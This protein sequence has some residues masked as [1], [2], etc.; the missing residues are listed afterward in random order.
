M[1]QV[2]PGPE[3]GDPRQMLGALA[4]DARIRSRVPRLALQTLIAAIAAFWIGPWAILW[5]AIMQGFEHK[6]EPW[7][8]ATVAPKLTP[9]EAARARIGLRF[10]MA[11]LF[12]LSWAP[13]WAVGGDSAAFFAAIMLSG[14]LIHS[15]VY[16]SNT[17]NV[18]YASIAPP[19]AAGVITPLVFH[20]AFGAHLLVIPILGV[21]LLRAHWAQRDQNALFERL[22]R[23]RE[24]RKEAEE[25]SR[26]KSRFLEIITHELRTP[27][28]AV[29]GYA[30]ILKDDLEADGKRALAADAEGIR[31]AGWR[32]LALV[33]DVIDF[34]HLDSGQL[35]ALRQQVDVG[36]VIEE[37][38]RQCAPL[39]A[40]GVA[41]ESELA[42][43]VGVIVTDRRR[44]EQCLANLLSNA[45]RF[46][47]RGRILI[48][49]R[50]VEGPER[51]LELAVED[52]GCGIAP[53]KVETL[54]E[55]FTQADASPTRAKDGLGLGLAI[56]R[57]LG[58]L[59]GGDVVVRSTPGV[60]S[61][62][63]LTVLA[64]PAASLHPPQERKAA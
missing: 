48:R 45:C 5:L 63:T 2:L 15:L 57:R 1:N 26:V 34:S 32:L 56:T 59:L 3:T 58:R 42:C 28:N 50:F 16:F 27:L 55:A 35:K 37:T 41:I 51:M 11:A 54:F 25:I 4:R 6:L 13:A 33:D 29:I 21:A 12:C 40:A 30:E 52:S 20:G 19:I 46:T 43:D 10:A 62:F 14:A 38:I 7:F 24:R 8:I 44:L 9:D 36:S 17:P 22:D 53:E 39:R 60:G 31:R 61:I 23:H 18:F 64:E 49:A 47:Q